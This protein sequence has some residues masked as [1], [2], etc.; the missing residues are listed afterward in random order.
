VGGSWAVSGGYTQVCINAG[1]RAI[2]PAVVAIMGGSRLVA[3]Q[4]SDGA[5]LLCRG[6]LSLRQ[7]LAISALLGGVSC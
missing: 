3:D 7:L 5:A 2:V 6:R 1:A 4:R